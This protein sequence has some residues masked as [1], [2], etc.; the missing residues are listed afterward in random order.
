[1]SASHIADGTSHLEA[2]PNGALARVCENIDR[3]TLKAPLSKA[4][5]IKKYHENLRKYKPP[6]G[7]TPKKEPT[8]AVTPTFG[9]PR[10]TCNA[11]VENAAEVSHLNATKR[12][13]DDLSL[14]SERLYSG[15][16]CASG[17]LCSRLR[18]GSV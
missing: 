5:A 12:S 11:N 18:S 17:G 9:R 7:K 16:T 3:T 14:V 15:K 10:S 2:K 6:T 13:F 1:M 4:E 8:V